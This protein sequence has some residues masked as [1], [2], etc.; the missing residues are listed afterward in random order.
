MDFSQQ[1]C[2]VEDVFI[3]F[4]AE[5][6]VKCV[7]LKRQWVLADIAHARVHTALHGLLYVG[8]RDIYSV[9]LLYMQ[10]GPEVKRDLPMAAADVEQ[11]SRPTQPLLKQFTRAPDPVIDF[12]PFGVF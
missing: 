6:G 7:I 10:N 4:A 2:R 3:H 9:D 1:V 12:P 8:I 5:D 11:P